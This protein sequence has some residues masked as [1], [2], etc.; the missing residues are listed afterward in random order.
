MNTTYFL[1]LVIGNTFKS[2]TTPAIPTATYIG[3]S[4]TQPKVDGTGV[5][6]PSTIT[7]SYT[8]KQLS[9]SAGM[10]SA[11]AGGIVTNT[12]TITFNE[13]TS[14]WGVMSYFVVYDAPTNGNLLMYGS[15][16]PVRTVET[17]TVLSIRPGAVQ[18]TLSSGTELPPN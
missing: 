3:L 8:R 13:S 11:P 7:T 5:T 2:Q 6:E 17:G 18:L 1:N 10:L 15:L 9:G 16:N 14:N 12:P 4:S